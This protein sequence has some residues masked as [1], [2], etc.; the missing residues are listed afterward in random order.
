M[1]KELRTGS[2]WQQLSILHLFVTTSVL[3]VFIVLNLPHRRVAGTGTTD[4][5]VEMVL[6]VTEAGWPLSFYGAV[7]SVEMKAWTNGS[8]RRYFRLLDIALVP[9]GINVAFN[10][11]LLSAFHFFTSL[12]F[13]IKK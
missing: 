6:I 9:L 11:G 3:A 8:Y 2:R 1:G 12:V 7:D 10:F 13:T 5:H 4:E